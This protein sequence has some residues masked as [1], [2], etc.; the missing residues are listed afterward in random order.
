MPAATFAAAVAARWNILRPVPSD[1]ALLDP[2]LIELFLSRFPSHPPLP[3][4]P[5][6]SWV[7]E[8][9]IRTGLGTF[10][11]MELVQDIFDCRVGMSSEC[12]LVYCW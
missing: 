3:E 6:V 10:T 8:R 12:L 7:R 2:S 5:D 11:V 4:W 1:V 9:V